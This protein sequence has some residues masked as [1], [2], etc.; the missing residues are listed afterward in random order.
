M[1]GTAI[2]VVPARW[3]AFRLGAVAEPGERRIHRG[4]TAR[5]GGLA[6]YLG[7]GIAAALFSPAPATLGLLLSAATITTLM[8]FDDLHGVRPLIKL[9]FQV[10]ASLLAIEDH[11]GRDGR[12][13]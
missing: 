13:R 7:F 8:V 1:I 12:R 2:A 6:L 11:Q 3:L 4:T 9:G 5:L 10:G